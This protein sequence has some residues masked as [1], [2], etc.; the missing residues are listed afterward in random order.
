MHCAHS[1]AIDWRDCT[2][3]RTPRCLSACHGSPAAALKEAALA[4][5]LTGAVALAISLPATLRLQAGLS[6]T[7]MKCVV[8]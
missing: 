7:L 6:T 2:L 1:Q 4:S 3:H 5:T 8:R